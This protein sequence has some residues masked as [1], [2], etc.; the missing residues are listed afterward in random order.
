MNVN[1]EPIVETPI[2]ALLCAFG[3]RIDALYLSG[4]LVDCRSCPRTEL[5]TALTAERARRL[6]EEWATVTSR[7]LTRYDTAER[8]AYLAE[9][10]KTSEWHRL[11]RAKYELE[12]HMLGWRARHAR[13]LIVGTRAHTRCLF[14]FQIL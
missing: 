4:L 7:Y 14:E 5:V 9:E 6:Y 1:R 13:V 2:D 11:Y 3:T 12:Q 8:D 10:N